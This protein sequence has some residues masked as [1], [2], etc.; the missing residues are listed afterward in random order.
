[1]YLEY[2]QIV[3]LVVAVLEAEEKTKL[4]LLL[5]GAAIRFLLTRLYD[6]IHQDPSALVKI[7]DPL[8]Y[9]RKLLFHRQNSILDILND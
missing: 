3:S 8:E 9:Q 5:R 4:P 7:K 2:V 6:W 1:M